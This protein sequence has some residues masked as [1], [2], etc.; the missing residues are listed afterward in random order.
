MV[1]KII[2]DSSTAIELAMPKGGFS[3]DFLFAVREVLAE[4]EG[5]DSAYVL[6]K[7][8]E[9][10]DAA[11]FFCFQFKNS[12]APSLVDARIARSMES[13]SS[14]FSD[15]V[16]LDATCLNGRHELLAAVLSIAGPIFEA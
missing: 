11:I 9:N 8:V 1:K 7:K 6:L 10:D 16:T 5:L 4:C 14:L 12:V 13:I 15:E 3:E 2:L